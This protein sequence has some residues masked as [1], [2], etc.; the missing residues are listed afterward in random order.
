MPC[1]E[2]LQLILILYEC[3]HRC[4]N[5]NVAFQAVTA[6][7]LQSVALSIHTALKLVYDLF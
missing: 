3:L 5:Y 4:L 1:A 6:H 2:K 7:K